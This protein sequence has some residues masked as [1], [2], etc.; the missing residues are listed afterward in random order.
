MTN[1]QLRFEAIGTH[2]VIDCFHTDKESSEIEKTIKERI[3]KFDIT[4][5]R[6]RKD[7]LIWK[8]SLKSGKY[9]LPEDS[10]QLFDNYRKIYN[11]TNG[12]VTPV[13]GDALES[14]GYDSEYSLVPKKIQ[15]VADIDDVYDWDYPIFHIKQPS[16]LDF[17]ALGKGYLIDIV[18]ELLAETGITSHIVDAGGDI[19][20]MNL[21]NEL[22]IGLENPKNTQ[23]AIGIAK[24]N[25]LSICASAGNRRKWDK[26]HHIF[27][28]KTLESTK[29]V[30]ATWVVAKDTITADALSTALFFVT[31]KKLIKY[32]KFDY[33]ILFPDL[34][35]KKS[36]KFPAELFLKNK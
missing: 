36:K 32:Y 15:K 4:Y 7:S 24:I 28:P 21:D 30:L 5:S 13:I 27:N 3:K 25:N 29:D 10:S 19:R 11:L 22:K 35:F 31:P 16:L 12:F 23:Q 33:L 26:Y 6:F 2:W 14:A 20:C 1:Y 34:K 8:A 9:T 17:G 18:S